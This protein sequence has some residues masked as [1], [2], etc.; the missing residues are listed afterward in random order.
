MNDRQLE[1]AFVSELVDELER[2]GD[3]GHA[4]QLLFVKQTANRAERASVSTNNRYHAMVNQGITTGEDF[5]RVKEIRDKTREF[6]L[7]TNR[8]LGATRAEV[9]KVLKNLRDGVADSCEQ[10]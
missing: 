7:V 4:N 9:I 10:G 6:E 2:H 3:Y 8:Y 1:T 5:D